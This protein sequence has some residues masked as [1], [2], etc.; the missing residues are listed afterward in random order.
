MVRM[1]D[2]QVLDMLELGVEGFKGIAEFKVF[3][4]YHSFL[5]TNYEI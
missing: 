1:F 5:L 3:I 2:F 4:H